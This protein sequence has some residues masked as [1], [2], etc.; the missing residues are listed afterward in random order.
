MEGYF[1]RTW[2]AR[3]Y[4]SAFM[5]MLRDEDNAKYRTVMKNVLE[6]DPR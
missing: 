5:H 1:V 4:N 3:V 2:H 6:F